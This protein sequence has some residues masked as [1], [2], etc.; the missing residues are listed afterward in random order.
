MRELLHIG[1]LGK[2]HGIKGA[3]SIYPKTNPHD[4]V[5]EL[6]L[7]LENGERFEVSEHEIHHNKAILFSPKIVDRT[8][9][10]A[11]TNTYLYCD[12]NDFFEK[13]PD[14]VFNDLCSGYQILDK[15]G[16]LIGILEEVFIIHDIPMLMAKDENQILHLALKANDIDHNNKTIELSYTL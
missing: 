1:T 6:D 11:W 15:D 12:K 5:F 2:P 7:F 14:Q 3:I 8:E 9:A 10:Q 4:I 16:N 13:H